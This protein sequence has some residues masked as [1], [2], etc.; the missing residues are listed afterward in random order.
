MLCEPKAGCWPWRGPLWAL[1]FM[2][3]LAASVQAQ[4]VTVNQ[5]ARHAGDDVTEW[6]AFVSAPAGA[7]SM[8]PVP[9]ASWGAL[10]QGGPWGPLA[11][12]GL[13]SAQQEAL[14]LALAGQ[15]TE[16]LAVVKDRGVQPDFRDEQGR[17][18]LTLAAQAGDLAAV[19]GLIAQGAD[20]DRVGARGMTPLGMAAWRGHELIARELLFVGADARQVDARGQTALHLASRMGQVRIMSMLIQAGARADALNRAGLPPLMEAA[21]MGQVSA[22]VRLTQAGVPLDQTDRHG[23]NAVHAAALAEQPQAVAWLTA[24][25]VPVQGALTQVLIDT[26]GRRAVVTR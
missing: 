16:V 24:Q 8:G 13:M 14:R 7:A 20:P 4:P 21:S 23:L 19:R 18:L 11:P 26:M 22:M 17:T 12:S 3:L 5:L 2:L 15:W 10:Q 1:P 6:S 25:G 9:D